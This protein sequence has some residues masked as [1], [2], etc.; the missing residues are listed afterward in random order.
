MR[1]SLLI[2]TFF[3]SC[4]HQIWYQVN[5]YSLVL[6]LSFALSMQALFFFFF[7]SLKRWKGTNS[8]YCVCRRFSFRCKMNGR[9]VFKWIMRCD[10]IRSAVICLLAVLFLF[11][12]LACSSFNKKKYLHNCKS[13]H[14]NFIQKFRKIQ[15]SF[16]D[17]M[18]LLYCISEQHSVSSSK[19]QRIWI[20]DQLS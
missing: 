12:I 11:L 9:R 14:R 3:R 7:L 20:N 13:W 2:T 10:L 5:F 16:T 1:S 6:Q 19:Y 18:F 8:Y 17:F 15:V 4:K